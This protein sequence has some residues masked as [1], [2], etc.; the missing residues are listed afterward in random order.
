MA[1][2][3]SMTDAQSQSS[4]PSA[5]E[6]GLPHPVAMFSARRGVFL[7]P[8]HG[9]L[10][11]FLAE[12]LRRQD[13]FAEAAASYRAACEADPISVEAAFGLAESLAAMV[14][15]DEARMAYLRAIEIDPTHVRSPQHPTG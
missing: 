3:Q 10:H 5:G 11:L 7:A 1:D 6:R 12:A 4:A 9:G 2:A 13:R 8:S 14:E 15:V